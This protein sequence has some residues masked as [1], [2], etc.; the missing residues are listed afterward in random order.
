M[1]FQKFL[2]L[3]GRILKVPFRSPCRYSEVKQMASDYQEAKSVFNLAL[4][5][6]GCG[7]STSIPN[8]GPCNHY[9]Y[10]S[11]FIYE[12]ILKSIILEP[13]VFNFFHT[14]YFDAPRGG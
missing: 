8:S 10:S 13:K 2:D 1:L 4:K 11:K 7:T 12:V 3:N 6:A 9:H 14:P 5:D